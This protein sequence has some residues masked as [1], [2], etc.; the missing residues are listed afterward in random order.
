[1]YEDRT[2]WSNEHA[3]FLDK[4]PLYPW[5]LRYAFINLSTDYASSA[6]QILQGIKLPHP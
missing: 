4:S 2:Q 1:M 3:D 6:F 5:L